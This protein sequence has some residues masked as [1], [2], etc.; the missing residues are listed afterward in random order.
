MAIIKKGKKSIRKYFKRVLRGYECNQGKFLGYKRSIAI[1]HRKPLEDED[2]PDVCKDERQIYYRKNCKGCP[3]ENVCPKKIEDRKPFLLRWMTDRFFDKRRN[4]NYK[5]RFAISE[6][7]NGFHKT[8]DCIIKFVGTTLNAI[9]N[10][11][12]LRNA[13]YNL[14]RMETF[15][16][17]GY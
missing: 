14:I 10:E 12:D 15:K 2:L 9:E 1:N 6:G 3:Y 16:E 5:D 17:E 13:I 4:V 8:S 7:I 11:C